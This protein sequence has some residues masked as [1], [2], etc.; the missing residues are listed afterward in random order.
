MRRPPT[1]R[2]VRE[3]TD[4]VSNLEQAGVRLVG[5]L[6]LLS[7][8][9]GSLGEA[10]AAMREREFADRRLRLRLAEHLEGGPRSVAASR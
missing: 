1:E 9:E 5:A 6:Q 8:G 3:I 10:M 7:Q 4:L 2:D